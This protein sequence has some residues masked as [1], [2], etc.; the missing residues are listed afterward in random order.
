MALDQEEAPPRDPP[1]SSTFRASLLLKGADAVLEVVGG[2][3]MLVVS[4]AGV[5]RLIVALTQHELSEDPADFI[6]VHLQKAVSH[7]G[8]SRSFAAAYL[9]S[10]GLGKII[11][12][13]AIFRGRLWAYP[14]M[15]VLLLL[16]IAYQIFRMSNVF[17]VGMLAL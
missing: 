12:V 8:S 6:A 14:G 10:H 1:L 9:L 5:S 4:P 3:L 16:F 2:V 7:F 13:A 15:I 17:T 11:L